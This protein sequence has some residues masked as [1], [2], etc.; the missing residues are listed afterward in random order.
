MMAEAGSGSGPGVLVVGGGI[1]GL[2]LARDL[3][4]AGRSV[5]VLEA[6]SEPGG[7]VRAHTVGGLRLDRGAESFATTRP[8]ALALIEELGLPVTSPVASPAWV[9]HE[10]GQAPLPRGGLL[11]IPADPRAADV[12][13]VIG[14]SGVLRA[15]LDGLLPARWGWSGGLGGVVRRRLGPRVLRRLV[16]PVA[17]GVY[18]S[19]PDGLD[20]DI[21]APGLRAAAARAGSLA[22]AVRELRGPAGTTPGAAVGGIVGGMARLTDALVAAI[23]ASGGEVRCGSPVTD[24]TRGPDGDWTVTVAGAAPTR[25]SAGTVVLSAPAAVTDRLLRTATGGAVGYPDTG[26]STTVAVV[27]LV[28]RSAALDAAPRGTGVLVASR[29]SGV[30]AKALTHATAK[31]PWLADEA[32]PGVHVLRLS[33]GRGSANGEA[34]TRLPE[35]S[36]LPAIALTDASDLLGVS[37]SGADLLDSAVVRFADSTPAFRSGQAEAITRMRADL[38]GFPGLLVTGAPVAG[39][40]LAAVVGDARAVARTLLDGAAA[41]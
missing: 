10:A 16:D 4:V 17:G 13:A 22:K 40:G 12:A 19:D 35:E 30:S 2:A 6:E 27:T 36:S 18:S 31:W 14:P 39:T 37:L 11:G 1:A 32:G 24:V 28:V 21:V 34:P 8:A 7:C 33:Y 15:R 38:T 26:R 41:G 9:R 3:A 29:A 20:V 5:L 23:R 25:I